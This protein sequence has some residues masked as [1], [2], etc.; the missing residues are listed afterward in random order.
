MLRLKTLL[1][2]LDSSF[3]KWDK[4]WAVS[5]KKLPKLGFELQ[6]YQKQYQLRTLTLKMTRPYRVLRYFTK[7]H[8]NLKHMKPWKSSPSHGDGSLLKPMMSHALMLQ[9]SLRRGDHAIGNP[10]RKK[11]ICRDTWAPNRLPRML[12][13]PGKEREHL[14][15]FQD[16]ST[17]HDSTC[18]AHIGIRDIP[19]LLDWLKG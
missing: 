8:Q 10:K 17:V 9:H 11:G 1:L 16:V 4:R 5:K 6:S 19:G 13:I 18:I 14:E 15:A 12:D 3:K 2:S 7:R